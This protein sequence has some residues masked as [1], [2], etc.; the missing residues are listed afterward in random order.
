MKDDNKY[1]TSWGALQSSAIILKG[2]GSPVVQVIHRMVNEDM[3]MSSAGGVQ[4][5]EIIG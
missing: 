1:A 2:K 5:E 4:V 3:L